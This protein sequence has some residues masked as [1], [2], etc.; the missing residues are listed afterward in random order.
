MGAKLSLQQETLPSTLMLNETQSAAA[1]NQQVPNRW[2]TSFDELPNQLQNF[3][4]L[5]LSVRIIY[6]LITSL[7]T[8]LFES[9]S[10]MNYPILNYHLQVLMIFVSC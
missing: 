5:S 7:L 4:I 9:Y 2:N 10:R 3:S 1:W 6:K 8:N